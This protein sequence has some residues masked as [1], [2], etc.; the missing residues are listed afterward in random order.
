MKAIGLIRYDVEDYVTTESHDALQAILTAM[1]QNGVPGSYGLV[2]KKAEALWRDGY[3]ETLASLRQEPALGFHSWSHSEHPT[4]AEQLEH[5]SF[6]AAVDAFVE[7]EAK[8]VSMVAD[9]IRPPEYFTQ[10]GANWVPAAVEALPKLGMDIFFSDA[11]NSYIVPLAEP[12]WLGSIL[13]L[14]PPVMTPKPFLLKFPDNWTKAVESLDQAATLYQGGK[15]F[16]VMAHPTELVTTKF[17]DAVNFGHG[18]TALA[19]RSAPLRSRTERDNTLRAFGQYLSLAKHHH[20]IEWLDV[21]ELKHRLVPLGPVTADPHA[22]LPAMALGLG[23]AIVERQSLSAAQQVYLLATMCA[24]DAVPSSVIIPVIK[25]PW[26]WAPPIED[27][28]MHPMPKNAV[29]RGGKWVREQVDRFG[30][31]P[32]LVPWEHGQW[33][34]E[35]FASYALS[36]LQ[37]KDK[38]WISPLKLPLQFLNYVQEPSRLHWDWPIFSTDFR[39][40]RLWQQT[41][42][43]VWSLK[44]ACWR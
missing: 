27:R 10:P 38:E 3:A 5:L 37:Q 18:A 25:A 35:D 41:L 44:R 32:S 24:T 28:P 23:P 33:P 34:I 19:L 22:W 13:H 12:Y 21:M 36:M 9:A 29:R 17:W 14:S 11:W 43:V 20:D 40:F 31:L 8:G 4:I 6:E 15:I 39:P 16:M 7:R 2:G 1:H 42:S 26:N 30:R